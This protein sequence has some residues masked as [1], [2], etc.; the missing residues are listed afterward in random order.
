MISMFENKIAKE[1]TGW[2]NGIIPFLQKGEAIKQR[3][4]MFEV[5]PKIK[6]IK[7]F[8]AINCYG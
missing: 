4:S 5:A 1:K 7:N 6:P 8:G 2:G 3:I